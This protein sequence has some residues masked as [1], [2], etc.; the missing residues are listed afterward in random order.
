MRDWQLGV[1][2][3]V[4]CGL[5][6]QVCAQSSTP[7]PA[8]T[9][10]HRAPDLR[11]WEQ[12]GQAQFDWVQM[13]SGEWLKG[14]VK[15]LREGTLSFDSD[16]FDLQ[17]LDWDDVQTLYSPKP[18]V[19]VFDRQSVAVGPAQLEGDELKI[20]T[21]D[22]QRAL[23]R[24][25]I[26][27]IV[28]EGNRELQHWRFKLSLGATVRRGNTQSI[29]YTA[30]SRLRR[31]DALNR[32]TL[33]YDGAFGLVSGDRNT[34]KHRGSAEWELFLSK[35]F[36][37]IPLFGEVL[38]DE[39]QNI[40]FRWIAATGGGFHI[41]DTSDLTLDFQLGA[42]YAQSYFVS[43]LPD[44]PSP[45]GGFLTLP[46]L[47]MNWDITSDLDFEFSWYSALFVP[48]FENTFHHGVA[49]FSVDVTDVIDL[50]LSAIYD[51]Q[52]EP[53][54]NEDGTVPNKNDLAMTASIGIDLD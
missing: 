7:V 16:K 33:E 40:E 50:G 35:Y 20:Q 11:P 43:T 29:D 49:R 17:E 32:F 30:Y 22:G 26:L 5:P 23:K 9:P 39:F 15:G 52:E 8:P 46:T 19:Y 2:L 38:H 36:F 21:V 34:N 45:A 44:D 13:T 14:E 6:G 31:E 41:V 24:D 27:S 18:H 4:L 51:R 25:R 12:E 48:N 3:L 54:P 37:L 28:R 47:T 10:E 1:G 53:T 42:G